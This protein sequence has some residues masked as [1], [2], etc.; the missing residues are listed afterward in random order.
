M[1]SSIALSELSQT[2][3]ATVGTSGSEAGQ[4]QWRYAAGLA[5]TRLDDLTLRMH[6]RY[7]GALS[8]PGY[9]K[10]GLR[11]TTKLILVLG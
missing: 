1:T 3:L 4:R 9:P 2:K 11:N 5:P 7:G 10:Y 8:S 6:F